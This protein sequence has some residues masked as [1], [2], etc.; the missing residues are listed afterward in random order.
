MNGQRI[1]LNQRNQFDFQNLAQGGPQGFGL[2]GG[3]GLNG[4]E[5]L[6]GPEASGPQAELMKKIEVLLEKFLEAMKA[7]QDACAGG[8]CGGGA[9]AGGAPAG[10]ADKAG[11][12]SSD[13]LFSLEEL[14]EELRK[15]AKQSPEAA[16]QLLGQNPELAQM[17][18]AQLGGG[19]A[20]GGMS[21]GGRSFSGAAGGV[22]V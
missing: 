19:A 4:S 14:L 6:T 21:G 11:G 15:L 7:Q 9:P 1:G 22:T 20:G 17:L 12:G 8:A 13:P 10:G 2:Q 3:Q 5:G 16:E 18:G